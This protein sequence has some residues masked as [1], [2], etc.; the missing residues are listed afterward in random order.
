MSELAWIEFVLDYGQFLK[1]DRVQAVVHGDKAFWQGLEFP[2]EWKSRRTVAGQLRH[3][4]W[5][6]LS[7]LEL[8]AGAAE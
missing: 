1:G 7:P 6:K 8:L 2:R 4:I 3:P 5:R